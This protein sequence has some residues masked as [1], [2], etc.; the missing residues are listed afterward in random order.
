MSLAGQTAG[1][2]TVGQLIGTGRHFEIY[3]ASRR[4]ITGLQLVL[5]VYAAEQ[6]ITMRGSHSAGM[7]AAIEHPGVAS[8]LDLGYLEDRRFYV[9]LEGM[10]GQTLD[11][12]LRARGAFSAAEAV[13]LMR[14]LGAAFAAIHDQNL[15]YRA[16]DPRHVFL[17]EDPEGVRPKIIDMSYCRRLDD[18]DEAQA[19][20]GKHTGETTRPRKASDVYGV[21]CLFFQMLTGRLPFESADPVESV[22]MQLQSPPPLL[23]SLRADAPPELESLLLR[24][25]AREP[26]E[27]PT[28]REVVQALGGDPVPARMTV[29]RQPVLV[30]PRRP[31]RWPLIA[32]CLIAAVGI[33]LALASLLGGG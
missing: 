32:G 12:R 17:H 10:R 21:G 29:A 33:A 14:W 27:R 1:A 16:I 23:R 24:M 11:D 25:L 2:Y 8:V 19:R 30:R 18:G 20:A 26:D 15:V 13:P 7:L 22:M 9:V 4:M 3:E 5:M 31:A 6:E 28:M